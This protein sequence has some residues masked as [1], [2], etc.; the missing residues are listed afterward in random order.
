MIVTGAERGSDGGDA[1]QVDRLWKV[2]V[3]GLIYWRDTSLYS[4]LSYIHC[5]S[6]P[7]AFHCVTLWVYSSLATFWG[8]YCWR[9]PVLVSVR[10][11]RIASLLGWPNQGYGAKKCALRSHCSV[12][13]PR[14]SLCPTRDPL[15][16]WNQLYRYWIKEIT[17]T[18]PSGFPALSRAFKHPVTRTEELFCLF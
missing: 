18:K 4:A 12:I 3:K 2:M 10:V 11:G 9:L 15:Q 13:Y 14:C 8:M 6:Y 17:S 1:K 16:N 5:T 7:G